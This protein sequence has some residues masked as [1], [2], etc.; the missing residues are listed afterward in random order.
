MKRKLIGIS[1]ACALVAG[2]GS[3]QLR[4]DKVPLSQVPEPVQKA[5]KA[6]SQGENLEHVDRETRDGQTVYQAEFKREGLNRHMTFA[7]D[8]KLLPEQPIGERIIGQRGPSLS[9]TDLPAA[10][11]K[12]V[13]EQQAGRDVAKIEK[14]MRDGKTVYNIEF[15]ETGVNSHLYVASDGSMVVDRSSTRRGIGERVR[16]KVG[17]DRDRDASAMT[18]EQTPAAVQKT[19]REHCDVGTLKPIKREIHDG[20]TEYKVEYEKEGKNLRLTVGEDGTVLKN[21]Q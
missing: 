14:E 4:A 8:G 15:K 11:Q 13:E 10:V 17:L 7:A 19:I 16:E 9:L 1:A 6:Q 12:T 20:R 2:A 3:Y 18:L 21:N 5:I